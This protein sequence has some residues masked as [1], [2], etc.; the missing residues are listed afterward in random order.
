MEKLKVG[1]TTLWVPDATVTL[2]FVAIC[3]QTGP[4]LT[5]PG[6]P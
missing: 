3:V 6:A 1:K 2:L 5:V 4:A